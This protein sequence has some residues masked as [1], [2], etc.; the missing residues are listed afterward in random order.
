ME[1]DLPALSFADFNS[2][3][4]VIIGVCANGAVAL[5]T[6]ILVLI[7]A[8]NYLK[9]LFEAA[10]RYVLLGVL[11][12]TAPVA[13]SMGASQTTANIWKSWCRMLGSG[14]RCGKRSRFRQ[15]VYLVSLCYRLSQSRPENRFLP[16]QS[17]CQCRTY[18]RQHAG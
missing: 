14:R 18:R 16:L 6:L 2:V 7:L 12:Y 15:C 5:I 13:F 17:W 1:S 3:M 4:L 8:W 9:L 10:E 11:V